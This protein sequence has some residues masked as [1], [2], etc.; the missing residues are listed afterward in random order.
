[1]SEIEKQLMVVDAQSPEE[2]VKKQRPKI[3]RRE[4]VNG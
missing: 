4:V 2:G 3:K 1:M